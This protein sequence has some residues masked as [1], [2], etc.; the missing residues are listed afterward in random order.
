MPARNQPDAAGREAAEQYLQSQGFR[1]LDR[2]WEHPDGQLDILA[3]ERGTLVVCDL[4]SRTSGYWSSLS[5]QRSHLLRAM[6]VD[7]AKVHGMI[8]G[9]IRIDILGLRYEDSGGFNFE[10]I[11]G[12][13]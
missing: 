9:Q 1:I 10:H 7:W 2:G 4:R 5:S 13:G 6:A 8:F 11:R 3:I 12:A